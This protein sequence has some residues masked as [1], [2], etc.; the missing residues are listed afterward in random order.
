LGGKSERTERKGKRKKLKR[1]TVGLEPG[2]AEKKKLYGD[3]VVAR[4]D[5]EREKKAPKTN[6]SN[7]ANPHPA[8][9]RRLGG[10]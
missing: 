2:H 1:V 7:A 8:L 10:I 4:K 5:E 9:P 6:S 3:K